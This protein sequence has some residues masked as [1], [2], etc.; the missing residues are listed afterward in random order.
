MLTTV[1]IMFMISASS[2]LATL[3]SLFFS[4]TTLIDGRQRIRADRLDS[5]KPAV[6]RA[7]DALIAKIVSGAKR[8]KCWG[9]RGTE[10]ERRGLLEG[11]NGN[12]YG[13]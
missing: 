2:A 8:L 13:H 9:D 1:I 7:R 4:L 10:D 6:Y 12:S 11:E 3:V 5:R